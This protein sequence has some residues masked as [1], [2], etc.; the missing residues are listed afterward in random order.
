M[1]TM[2]DI[3]AL[4]AK[5][6]GLYGERF[7]GLLPEMAKEWLSD[8]GHLDPEVVEGGLRRWTRQHTFKPPSL[9]ELIE[10]IEYVR[11][12]V[13]ATQRSG[14]SSKSYLEVLQ[15]AAEAQGANPERSEDDAT[16][17]RL[18]ALLAERAIGTW[19]DSKKQQHPKLT[20]EQ[21]GEQCYL[22][23]RKYEATRPQLADDLRHAAKHFGGQMSMGTEVYA[24]DREGF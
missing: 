19:F 12:E 9:D 11:E 4:V 7:P 8:L 18:M 13:R 15:D 6:K 22:W 23:A 21:R 24:N 17:G 14:S 10:Q 3:Q 5:L 16:Y 20:M 2:A 1:M